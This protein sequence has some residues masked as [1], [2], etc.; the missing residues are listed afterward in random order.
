MPFRINTPDVTHEL[1]DGEVIIVN[2][3][4]GAYY[5]LN[6]S[7]ATIWGWLDGGA[8]VEAIAKRIAGVNGSS[9]ESISADLLRFTKELQSEGL[10]TPLQS[11]TI[12]AAPFDERTTDGI[13][14]YASPKFDKYSDME[15]LLLVDPIH[16]VSPHGWPETPPGKT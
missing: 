9:Q 7:A 12:P 8:E 6:G 4:T 11:A 13:V 1:V 3:V 15:E 10:I 2:V 16:E 5:S 14:P